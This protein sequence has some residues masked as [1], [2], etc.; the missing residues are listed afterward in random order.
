MWIAVSIFAD[1]SKAFD[2]RSKHSY[3][4]RFVLAAMLILGATFTA[5]YFG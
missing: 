5:S 1:I 2:R 4:W 3:D